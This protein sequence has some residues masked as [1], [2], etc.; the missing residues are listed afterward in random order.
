MLDLI[1]RNARLAPPQTE[2]SDIGILDGAFVEIHPRIE[3]EARQTI[4]AA[5]LFVTPPLV[6]SHVHLDTAMTA[7][8]PRWNKSGTLFEGIERWSERKALLSEQDVLERATAAVTWEVAHGVL[9]IRSHVDICD[10]DLTALRALLQLKKTMAPWVD[11]QLVAFPQ[12]GIL[13]YPGG[14]HLLEDALKAGADAVG[15]IPHYE[16]TREDGVESLQIVFAL[17]EKYG[18]LV[19]VHCDE[20]DDEQSRFVEVMSALAL[21]TGL[22]EMVT[23]SHTTAMHSYGGAYAAKLLRFC[24]QSGI[25]FVA[26]PL[27]NIHLQGRFDTYPKRRGLTRIKEMTQMGINVSLGHDDILDPWYP[28]GTG[29]MLDVAHMAAHVGQMMGTEEQDAVFRMITY[30]GA[31]TLNIEDSY[32]IS[33]G[34]PADL[35]VLDA[36]DG[37]DAIR[38]QAVA[39]FVVSRGRIVSQTLPA[40]TSVNLGDGDREVDFRM[41]QTGNLREE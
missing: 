8:Q 9:H 20:I 34:M 29:S 27:V 15:G 30:G 10:P 26:N 5:G 41:S 22:R 16:L 17:A 32:G 4:D 18:R 31:R 24:A 2:L 36:S 28:M 12:D 39:R 13:G 1:V 23:A 6:E 21:R 37:R 38:R 40:H 35:V 19:D 25:N 14:A 11:I 33:I 3:A 7:G